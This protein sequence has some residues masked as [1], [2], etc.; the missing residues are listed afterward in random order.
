VS[1]TYETSS[2][3][4]GNQATF[5]GLFDGQPVTV[6]VT[7]N[8]GQKLAVKIT[9]ASGVTLFQGTLSQPAGNWQNIT[10][11]GP[12]VAAGYADL[13]G[14]FFQSG[15]A[16]TVW[17]SVWY[18]PTHTFT[19][20]ESSLVPHAPKVAGTWAPVYAVSTISF[21]SVSS[22]SPTT[23]SNLVTLIGSAAPAPGSSV[24][25]IRVFVQNIAPQ[26]VTQN[27]VVEMVGGQ[28]VVK[29]SSNGT[30]DP[31]FVGKNNT[32]EVKTPKG[33]IIDTGW[34]ATKPASSI[35]PVLFQSIV[36]GPPGTNTS[37]REIDLNFNVATGAI[38]GSTKDGVSVSGQAGKPIVVRGGSAL[39]PDVTFTVSMV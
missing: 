16:L 5:S 34:Q 23:T 8:V 24:V 29:W 32:W 9:A 25:P 4:T 21:G 37:V 20:A 28:W 15:K 26:L 14:R 38:T 7:A 17:G 35:P 22:P 36:F 6:Q 3:S 27:G 10:G 39:F 19:V 30:T 11:G 1:W 31:L 33:T 12:Q 2:S 18:G 13:F